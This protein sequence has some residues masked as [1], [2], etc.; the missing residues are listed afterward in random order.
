MNIVVAL[1][2]TVT[3]SRLAIPDGSPRLVIVGEQVD[4]PDTQ[5]ARVSD[6]SFHRHADS[7]FQFNYDPYVAVLIV[8]IR[9]GIHHFL[10]ENTKGR[11]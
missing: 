3:R 9:L 10:I 2:V 5:V 11:I 4:L 8:L 6:E 7:D 1:L